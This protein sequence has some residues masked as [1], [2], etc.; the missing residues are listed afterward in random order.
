MAF[1]AIPNPR[2]VELALRAPGGAAG[3]LVLHAGAS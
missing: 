3:L 1:L 2:A